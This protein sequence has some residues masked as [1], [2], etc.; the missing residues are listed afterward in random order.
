MSLSIVKASALIMMLLH[1]KLTTKS[2]H[3]Y[4]RA[5]PRL[6]L[7]QP[8]ADEGGVSDEGFSKISVSC[9]IARSY[10]TRR[11]LFHS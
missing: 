2:E 3:P 1:V 6:R 8:N 4:G 5:W 11:L 9:V 7:R 10:Q